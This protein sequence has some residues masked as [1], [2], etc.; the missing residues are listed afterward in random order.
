MA[1]LENL[2]KTTLG[3]LREMAK[4]QSVVG[5]PVE[6]GKTTV[7]PLVKLGFGFGGGGAEDKNGGRSGTGGG[8]GVQPVAVLVVKD[9]EVRLERMSGQS[10]LSSATNTMVDLMKTVLDRW[11]KPKESEE[12]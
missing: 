6:V 3:E 12:K 1:D 11:L 2:V 4:A 10:G 7:I 8:G 9:G 5:D